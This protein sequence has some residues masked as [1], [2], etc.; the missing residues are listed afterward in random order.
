MFLVSVLAGTIVSLRY[1][2][3]E[4]TPQQVDQQSQGHFS[5]IYRGF[6]PDTYNASIPDYYMCIN[7][8]AGDTMTMKLYMEVKNQ[9]STAYYIKTNHA[10]GYHP[11]GWS[12][13]QENSTGGNMIYVGVDQTKYFHIVLTRDRPSSIPEGRIT[14]TLNLTVQA[15]YDKDYQ[16]FY[17]EDFFNATFH[18]IDRT[19]PV[20]TVLCYNNFDDATTQGWTAG[21]QSGVSTTLYRSYRYSFYATY[22]QSPSYAVAM[23]T[24]NVPETFNEAYLIFA[25]YGLG[26]SAT[27]IRLNGTIYFKPDEPRK[28][29]EWYQFTVPIF[30]GSTSVRIEHQS[31]VIRIDDVYVIAR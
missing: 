22:Y 12:F 17:D 7:D 11:P 21:Y 25:S 24:F 2:S 16:N 13:S 18:F 8:L 27:Q 29:N 23:K 28:Y 31:W 15:F 5:V 30:I 1:S 26:Y 6:V 14:E 9:E 20:W 3:T 10:G 4:K 19:A